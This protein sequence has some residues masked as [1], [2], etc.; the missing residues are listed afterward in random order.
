MSQEQIIKHLTLQSK[1]MKRTIIISASLIITTIFGINASATAQ[2]GFYAGVQGAPQLSVIFNEDDVNAPNTDYK[3][4]FS[5]T[6]GVNGGYN[7]TQRM[8]IGTEVMYSSVKQNYENNKGGYTQK[9]SY[10]K[11]PLLFTYN[12]SPD[13]RVVFTAKAGPQVSILMKSN[14]T[15]AGDPS[16]NGSNKNKYESL[17]F[18]ATAGAGARVRL[19]DNISLNAGLRFD[20]S[21]GN[22]ED[23]S[24]AGHTSGRAKTYDLNSGVEV[25]LR[26][27]FN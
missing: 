2:K 21:I 20:G 11:V 8:G 19:T 23:K 26:Y 6:F 1:K 25:G 22:I 18:G 4:K 10:L 12:S 24:Y 15:N 13:N 3:A 17:V 27:Q 16:L 9:L 7:F 14:V 5:Y